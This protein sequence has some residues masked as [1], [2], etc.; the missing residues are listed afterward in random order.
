MFDTGLVICHKP[1]N[2]YYCGLNKWD[3]QLRKAKIYHKERY[4]MEW[5]ENYCKEEN[6]PLTD[7]AIIM[8]RIETVGIKE[9]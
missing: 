1:S 3:K 4:L 2:T 6:E 9:C 5:L 7:Y 8:I